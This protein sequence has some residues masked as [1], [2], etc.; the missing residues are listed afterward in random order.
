MTNNELIE[1]IRNSDNL[2]DQRLV[3]RFDRLQALESHDDLS[4][5]EQ[6]FGDDLRNVIEREVAW[7]AGRKWKRPKTPKNA[8]KGKAKSRTLTFE[9]Q[10]A[11]THY[12]LWVSYFPGDRQEVA[13][14]RVGRES[15]TPHDRVH[16]PIIYAERGIVP[17]YESEGLGKERYRRVQKRF[18]H[19]IDEELRKLMRPIVRIGG[20]VD[21]NGKT[22]WYEVGPR[23]GLAAEWRQEVMKHVGSAIGDWSHGDA[24]A[25]MPQWLTETIDNTKTENDD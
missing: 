18:Y 1:S 8:Y 24:C 6:H 12:Q 15:T 25:L 9:I 21:E 2:D 23:N 10:I 22:I 16:N 19:L 4:Q 17:P 11:G 7:L 14:I 20:D 5:E 13:I 3:A